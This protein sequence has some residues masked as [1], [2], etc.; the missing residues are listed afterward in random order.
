MRWSICAILLAAGCSTALSAINDAEVERI[1]V[2]MEREAVER[3]V[4]GPDATQ[5]LTNGYEIITYHVTLG[6]PERDGLNT[7]T[8]EATAIASESFRGNW[9]YLAVIP[10]A[11]TAGTF[12]VAEGINIGREAHRL[13]Q[14][15]RHEVIVTYGRDG[16]VVAHHV[17]V[18]NPR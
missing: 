16:R 2:G 7:G 11:I 13:G 18:K 12:V 4:G 3:I 9:G 10:L 15:E 17:R 14:G 1:H 5:K 6:I 8:M